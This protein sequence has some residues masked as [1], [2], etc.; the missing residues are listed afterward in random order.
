MGGAL[1]GLA[2]AKGGVGP[3]ALVKWGGVAQSGLGHIPALALSP[4][5]VVSK[6]PSFGCLATFLLLSAGTL[7]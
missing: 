7:S 5:S 3:P 2:M 1:A 6:S 4:L